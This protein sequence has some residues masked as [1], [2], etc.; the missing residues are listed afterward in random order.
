[1]FSSSDSF[2]ELI[3]PYTIN[4]KKIVGSV[5][6]KDSTDMCISIICTSYEW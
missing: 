1:M 2:Y 6:V 5:S 4:H 3:T